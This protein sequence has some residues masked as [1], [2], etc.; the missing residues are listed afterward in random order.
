MLLI[1]RDLE[2][3]QLWLD[4]VFPEQVDVKHGGFRP[5]ACLYSE[6]ALECSC[7]LR[8]NEKTVYRQH[9]NI[10]LRVEISEPQM[11]CG[12]DRHRADLAL[13]S[14]LVNEYIAKYVH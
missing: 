12:V 7:W 3:V 4:Y 10:S 14:S 9:D 8:D 2:H 1:S 6:F 13:R 5:P 11:R